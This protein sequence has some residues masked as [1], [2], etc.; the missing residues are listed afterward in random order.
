MIGHQMPLLDPA[1]LLRGQLL[2]YVPEVT[3][4]FAI[5]RLSQA[6][7]NEHNVVFAVQLRVT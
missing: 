2:E 4:Q 5:Q 3:P 6:F 1:L 7:G